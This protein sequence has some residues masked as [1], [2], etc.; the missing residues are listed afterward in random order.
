[1]IRKYLSDDEQESE[2]G[3]GCR[4]RGN[5]PYMVIIVSSTCFEHPSFHP[6][7]DLYV[8][9][10]VISFKQSYKQS[11]RRQDVLDTLFFNCFETLAVVA[12]WC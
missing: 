4:V 7:E 11:G 5:Q 10:Y 1:M 8:Q 6:Q 9:F 12:V 2:G 3:T